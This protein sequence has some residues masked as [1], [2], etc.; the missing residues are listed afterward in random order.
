LLESGIYEL[1]PF[2]GVCV[3]CSKPKVTQ[4]ENNRLH[5]ETG[6]AVMFKD[7][8]E[9]YFWRGVNVPKNWIMD[10]NSI[11]KETIDGEKNAEK[12]RCIQEI[13]GHKRYAELLNIEEIDSDTDD[14]GNLMSLWRTKE[15][16]ELLQDFIYYY[17]GICPSTAREYVLCVP[18]VG[19]VWEAKAWTFKNEKIQARHGDVGLLNVEETFEK[20][21]SET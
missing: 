1:Y 15:K 13:I 8:F 3:V 4:D 5:N 19:N 2:E 16:D 12:R 14:Q 9:M 11:T 20:P 21:T 6:P 10:K 18:K 17:K 7:N